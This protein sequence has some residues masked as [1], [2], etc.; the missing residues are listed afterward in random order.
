MIVN[1]GYSDIP[2]GKIATVVTSLEM[3]A[4]APL[5]QERASS[6]WKINRTHRPDLDWYRDLYR[7]V[8]QD[9]LWFSRLRLADSDLQSIIHHKSVEIYAL[10]IQGKD[11]GLLELDFR[12][13]GECELAF[14]GLTSEQIGTGA[15]RW[16]INRAIELAWSRPIKRFWV[17]TCTLDHP[18]A[19]AFYIRS[20]F[21]PY[22][23]Q[24]EIS[25]DPRLDGT[26]P[27]HVAPQVPII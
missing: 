27:R 21:H 6:D 11:E 16:L 23:Q 8:G 20:G 26:L 1:D 3:L 10:Q 2:K 25:D 14:L 13:D 18:Q 17:H 5:R 12:S 7:R 19:L 24:I 9:W 4:R 22:R 15:G